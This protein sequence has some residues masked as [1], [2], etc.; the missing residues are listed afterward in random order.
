MC[1]KSGVIVKL[2]GQHVVAFP[3]TCNS[4]SC[5]DCSKLRRKRLI[6]EALKGQPNRFITLTVNPN[7]FDD[8]EDRARRL[9]KAWRLVVAAFRHRWP[10]REAEY[11][12]VFEATKRGE[13]HLHIVWR[14]AFMP[15]KW[16]SKQMA[17]R[18]GAPIVDVRRIRD[19]RKVAEYCFKYISKRPVRFGTLKR[20]WR[21]KHYLARSRTAEKR[22]RN[23]GCYFF[24]SKKHWT[25]YAEWVMSLGWPVSF[26]G[27]GRFE[28]DLPEGHT[29]PP[30]WF[31]PEGTLCGGGST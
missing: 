5:P 10:G 9:A 1:T 19:K 15:Q 2:D 17:K 31:L 27:G 30:W 11:L 3:I 4:W 20:Y 29:F 23:K 7:W 12:A 21:S 16:L 22:E 6:G 14:G 18:M 28:F 25:Y 26:A 8:P 13:P 24:R